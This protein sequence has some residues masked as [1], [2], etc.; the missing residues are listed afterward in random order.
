MHEATALSTLPRVAA[1]A[2]A[3]TDSI[4]IFS[5]AQS[6]PIPAPI[7]LDRS[8]DLPPLT[9]DITGRTTSQIDPM[10]LARL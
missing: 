9:L 10:Y 3:T 2:A 7:L 5:P 4:Q 8:E 6:V 1:L